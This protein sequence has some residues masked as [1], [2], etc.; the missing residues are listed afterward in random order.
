MDNPLILALTIGIGLLT[1]GCN[2]KFKPGQYE[3]NSDI[4][5]GPGL[6]SGEDGE[7]VIYQGDPFS[8]KQKKPD[9]KDTPLEIEDKPQKIQK[10]YF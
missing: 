7:F 3:T 5:P 1:T 4:K 6:F 8:S 2:G 10:H 9:G